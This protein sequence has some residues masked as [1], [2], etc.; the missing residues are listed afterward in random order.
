MVMNEGQKRFVEK[1]LGISE[2]DIMNM[3]RDEIRDLREKFFDI[4]TEE[5][6]KIDDEDD[7]ISSRGE[8]AADIVDLLLD[9]LEEM[10]AKKKSA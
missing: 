5:A 1:E 4:E 10:S 3:S 9:L 7:D 6:M 2:N 8:T